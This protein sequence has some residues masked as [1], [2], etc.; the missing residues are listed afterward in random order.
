MVNLIRIGIIH[1]YII[2]GYYTNTTDNDNK[3]IY[4]LG[5][6]YDVTQQSME[7]YAFRGLTQ[8]TQQ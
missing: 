7:L 1:I 8:Y 6:R 5:D 4:V 2:G 3:L